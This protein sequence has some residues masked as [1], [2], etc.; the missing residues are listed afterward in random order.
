[1]VRLDALSITPSKSQLHWLISRLS[2]ALPWCGHALKGLVSG[3]LI[4]VNL[5]PVLHFA[6]LPVVI[7]GRS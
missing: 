7:Y 1:M 6:P 4:G 3:L 2:L 5:L